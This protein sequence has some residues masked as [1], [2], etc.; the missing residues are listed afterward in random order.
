MRWLSTLLIIPVIYAHQTTQTKVPESTPAPSPEIV[1]SVEASDARADTLKAYLLSK[2][3]PLADSATY[4]V[5]IA[6]TYS[7]DY[8]L[9][10]AIAG[11]ES[12]FETTGNTSDFNPFG[13][14]CEGR[15]CRFLSYSEAITRVGRSLGEGRAYASFRSSGSLLELAKKYNYVSP[16]DWTSKVRYFQQQIKGG[17]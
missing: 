16:E 7:L 11:V 14:M 17:E 9:L 2:K 5:R 13:Y 1:Q 8:T 15:P 6:D 4:F 12:G 10:P 3:S